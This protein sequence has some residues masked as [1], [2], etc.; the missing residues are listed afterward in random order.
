MEN[1]MKDMTPK[2]GRKL[3][4]ESSVMIF[5][6]LDIN[7]S[8]IFYSFLHDNGATHKLSPKGVTKVYKGSKYNPNENSLMIWTLY[9][10]H[11]KSMI[12][13]TEKEF[14]HVMTLKLGEVDPIATN[15]IGINVAK[16]NK[17]RI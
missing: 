3:F 2:R 14:G 10:P 8:L 4:E 16:L 6:S 12:I 5:P 11:K 15:N 9:P 1:E 13:D 17:T 7:F